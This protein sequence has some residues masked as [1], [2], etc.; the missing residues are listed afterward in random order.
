MNRWWPSG[1][2]RRG[3]VLAAGAVLASTLTGCSLLGGSGSTP[4][5]AADTPTPSAS[6]KPSPSPTV[7]PNAKA[8]T[9]DSAVRFVYY[10]FAA[11]NHAT[12]ELTSA[13]LTPISDPPC[14]F[15]N[16]A[17][18]TI[19]QLKTDGRRAEG[20]RVTLTAAR[21]VVGT[22]EKGLRVNVTY[23]QAASSILDSSGAT[24]S[25]KPA[26]TAGQLAVA[27]K[28]NGKA[29]VAQEIVIFS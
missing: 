2:R 21:A 3:A 18:Q 16:R 23:N 9:R 17:K 19:D 26:V 27:L 1:T 8:A 15:C 12:W 25:T 11:Y 14:V 4:S 20:G 10:W 29:W 5:V 22:P 28:W 7:P 13:E 6:T 24:L